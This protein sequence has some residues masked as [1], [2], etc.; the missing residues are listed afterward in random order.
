MDIGGSKSTGDGSTIYLDSLMDL[1]KITLN[2][3]GY[4]Y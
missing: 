1:I 4:R 2:E 3:Q